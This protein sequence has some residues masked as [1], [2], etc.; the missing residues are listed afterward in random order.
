MGRPVI[1]ENEGD[2]YQNEMPFKSSAASLSSQVPFVQRRRQEKNV[3]SY[4]NESASH[5]R[6]EDEEV[7]GEG[8]R[9]ERERDEE[10][11]GERRESFHLPF[12]HADHDSDSDSRI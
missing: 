10:R 6:P 4:L 8:K 2:K 5:S 11:R 9:R 1:L 7:Q 12:P 3:K